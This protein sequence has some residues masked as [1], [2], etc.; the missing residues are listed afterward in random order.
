MHNAIFSVK[1]QTNFQ[2]K[3]WQRILRQEQ[4]IIQNGTTN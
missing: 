3:K 2:I 4:K 1:L